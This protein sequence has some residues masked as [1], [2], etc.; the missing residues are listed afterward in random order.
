MLGENSTPFRAIA[1]EHYHRNG[2]PMGVI[3]VRASYDLFPDGTLQLKEDQGIVLS[4]EYEGDQLKTPLLRASDIIPFKPNTDITIIGYTYPPRGERSSFWRFGI[5]IEKIS[6]AFCCHGLRRWL[7]YRGKND[8]KCW[9]MSET[10]PVDRVPLDYR[11]CSSDYVAGSPYNAE[12]LDNPLGSPV[13]DPKISPRDT[14][15]AVAMIT[16]DGDLV[17]NP[18]TQVRIAGTAPIAPYWKLR[19]R[20]AGSYDKA[21]EQEKYPLLPE[22]FDYLFYQTAC[23]GMIWRGFMRGDETITL[24]Q[25]TCGYDVVRFQLPQI[26]PF[27]R[28]NWLDDRQIALSLNFDGLHCDLRG[29]EPPWRIDLTW[30]GWVEICPQFFKIDL[31]MMGINDGSEDDFLRC[32]IDGLAMGIS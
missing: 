5:G 10:Q 30:R 6:V 12:I 18:F 20:F 14:E 23:P 1:F 19:R 26:Q 15:V 32:N 17:I 25:M 27:A 8:G 22:D 3:A 7:P 24:R 13:L 28:I 9:R 29:S 4:D 2:R 31:F 11:F 21:W 16:H